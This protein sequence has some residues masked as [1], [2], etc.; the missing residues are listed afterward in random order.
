MSCR[1]PSILI[2]TGYG[3]NCEA[4]SRFAWEEAGAEAHLLHLSDLLQTPSQLH[5]YRGLMFIG[6]FS[7]GDHMGSGHVLASRL[8]NRMQEDL[9]RFVNQGKIV[10]GVC[11]GFQ[12]LL[13][14]GLLPGLDRIYTHPALALIHNDCGSFQN[15][16]VQ[17]RCE[18]SGSSIF[19]KGVDK[20]SLPV[21]HG[22]G[23]I[24][25]LDRAMVQRLEQAGCIAC[26]YI[27]PSTG[28]PTLKPPFNPNGSIGAIAGLSDPTGRI[29][30]MMPH[31]EAYLSPENHPLWHKQREQ[32]SL[33]KKGDGL[34]LFENAV[35]YLNSS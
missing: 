29:F 10:M 22:E 7:Y 18:P 28:I 1:K 2:I 11:N 24:F 34:I 9:L 27:D 21:R 31:P 35:N 20:L 16:W 32:H 17:I 3:L 25:T 26:R 6:G 13:K 33:P 5:N 12:I 4:E 8:Q 14:L 15:V 23:K 19:T 30:G